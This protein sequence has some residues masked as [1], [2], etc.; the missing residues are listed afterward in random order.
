MVKRGGYVLIDH[1]QDKHPD[2]IIIA[3]GSEVMLA[4][5]AANQLRDAGIFVR[6]VSMPST[7]VFLA[8]DEAIS[9]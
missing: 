4:V 8:Q 1:A 3:T 6:V 2:A 5:D 9:T 7:D